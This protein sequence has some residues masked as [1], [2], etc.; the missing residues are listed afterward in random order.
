MIVGVNSRMNL[1]AR[2]S[3]KKTW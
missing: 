2:G 1:R 3:G